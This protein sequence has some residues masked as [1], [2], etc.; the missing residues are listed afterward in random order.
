[1]AKNLNPDK[2]QMELQALRNEMSVM[3]KRME[4]VITILGGNSSY[5]VKGVRSELKELT[6]QVKELEKQFKDQVF[7]LE[8]KFEKIEQQEIERW[9]I[10]LKTLPQKVVAVIAFLAL[11]LTI[12][13]NV[14]SLL[15]PVPTP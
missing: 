2:E 11:L 14:K 9:S 8:E 5:G 7:A 12:V 15:T 4:E 10:P 13:N 3:N 1:M 6:A